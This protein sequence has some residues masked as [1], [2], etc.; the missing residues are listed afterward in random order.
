MPLI[1]DKLESGEFRILD[2]AEFDMGVTVKRHGGII[3][4]SEEEYQRLS[5]I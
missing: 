4:V 1:T 3:P 5:V 2:D